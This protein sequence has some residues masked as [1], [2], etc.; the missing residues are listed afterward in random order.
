LRRLD[1][2][3]LEGDDDVDALADEHLGLGLGGFRL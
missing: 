3:V 1:G 2:L